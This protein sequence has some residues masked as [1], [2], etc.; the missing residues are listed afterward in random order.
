MGA[1]VIV[2]LGYLTFPQKAYWMPARFMFLCW[3]VEV[4]QRGHP[5]AAH[6]VAGGPGWGMGRA[7]RGLDSSVHGT[8]ESVVLT[9][10]VRRAPQC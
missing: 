4:M 10:K 8:H 3:A 6:S 9:V 7:I 1:C 5:W 2:T